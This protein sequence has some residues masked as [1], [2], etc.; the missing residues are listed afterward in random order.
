MS[1]DGGWGPSPECYIV[2][3]ALR[4]PIPTFYDRSPR[5]TYRATIEKKYTRSVSPRVRQLYFV[6][7]SCRQHEYD[8]QRISKFFKLTEETLKYI[9]YK[10]TQ[11]TYISLFSFHFFLSIM[12]NNSVRQS[13]CRRT[14]DTQLIQDKGQHLVIL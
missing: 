10:V 4:S 9:M 3:V 2:P 12:L 13:K 6:R 8:V 5:A 14:I 7:K 1:W 11:T